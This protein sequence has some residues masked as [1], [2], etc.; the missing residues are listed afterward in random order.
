[1]LSKTEYATV[2]V[3]FEPRDVLRRVRHEQEHHSASG[4]RP[5]AL[6]LLSSYCD[7]LVLARVRTYD[8]GWDGEQEVV[9]V[10]IVIVVRLMGGPT[11]AGSLG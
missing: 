5:K 1:M 2:L 6:L 3:L 4:A 7:C 11:V 9:M 8:E 10:V